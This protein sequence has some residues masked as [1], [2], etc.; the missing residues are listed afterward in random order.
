MKMKKMMMICLVIIRKEIQTS[1]MLIVSVDDKLYSVIE[2]VHYLVLM[3]RSVARKHSGL[4][5]SDYGATFFEDIF[6]TLPL[7][8]LLQT[9]FEPFV[10]KSGKTGCHFYHFIFGGVKVV[11]VAKITTHQLFPGKPS[12]PLLS[13]KVRNIFQRN[14]KLYA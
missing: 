12:F 3:Q 4:F 2:H 13:R 10:G 5:W 7:L 9:F 6:A 11:K 1:L 8:P 14:P